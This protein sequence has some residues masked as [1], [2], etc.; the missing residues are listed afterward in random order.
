MIISTYTNVSAR[1]SGNTNCFSSRLAQQSTGIKLSSLVD[2]TYMRAQN[3][4]RATMGNFAK[5]NPLCG[6]CMPL[7]FILLFTSLCDPSVSVQTDNEISDT[8][9]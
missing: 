7:L 3:S 6:Y 2:T 5:F 9:F 1:F 4:N 8:C